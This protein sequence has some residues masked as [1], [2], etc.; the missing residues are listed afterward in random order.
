AVAAWQ[1]CGELYGRVCA[2]S[3]AY[4]QPGPPA[5]VPDPAPAAAPEAGSPLIVPPVASMAPSPAETLA[6]S[7]APEPD[8]PEMV[9]AAKTLKDIDVQM[10]AGGVNVVL[11]GDG[12]FSYRVFRLRSNRLVVDLDDVINGTKSGTKS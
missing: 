10:Q 9:S 12:Q 3:V 5:V 2:R 6:P 11:K 8:A 1:E 7:V 4:A